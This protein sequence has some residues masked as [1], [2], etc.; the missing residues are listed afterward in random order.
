MFFLQMELECKIRLT[1]Y[2]KRLKDYV[3]L[4]NLL[5]KLLLKLL[6]VYIKQI[7]S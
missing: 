7:L 2:N 4:V 3:C 6:I 1:F 5:W